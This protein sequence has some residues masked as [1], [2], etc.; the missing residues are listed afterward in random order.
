MQQGQKHKRMKDAYNSGHLRLTSK[1]IGGER[2]LNRHR[3]S[4]LGLPSDRTTRP[5]KRP[6]LGVLKRWHI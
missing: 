2:L 6:L 5:C 3:E 1:D 4:A